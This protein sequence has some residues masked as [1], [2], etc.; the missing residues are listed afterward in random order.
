MPR[1]I[2]I[3]KEKV[4]QRRA[5]SWAFHYANRGLVK[6]IS[7]AVDAHRIISIISRYVPAPV[8]RVDGNLLEGRET[9]RGVS[10]AASVLNWSEAQRKIIC[11][12]YWSEVYWMEYVH[13]FQNLPDVEEDYYILHDKIIDA[14]QLAPMSSKPKQG[15]AKAERIPVDKWGTTRAQKVQLT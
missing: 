13:A 9:F 14:I 10:E 15:S 7:S 2:V 1:R 12:W 4:Y 11:V 8:L 3:S 5:D 6:Q